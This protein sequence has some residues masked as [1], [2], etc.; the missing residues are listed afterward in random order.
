MLGPA[1]TISVITQQSE[2]HSAQIQKY[3]VLKKVFGP[4]AVYCTTPVHNLLIQQ[5]FKMN[6]SSIYWKMERESYTLQLREKGYVACTNWLYDAHV[7]R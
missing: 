1:S 5:N 2:V 6:D 7:L 3:V 4:V